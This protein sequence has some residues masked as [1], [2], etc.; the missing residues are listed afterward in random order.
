MLNSVLTD[1]HK[2]GLTLNLN[3]LGVV[4]FTSLAE[5]VRSSE[6]LVDNVSG[7]VTIRNTVSGKRLSAIAN[8]LDRDEA[9]RKAIFDA[10]LVTT[11][12]RAAQAIA[13]P[14]IACEHVHFA[15]NRKTS[16]AT[17]RDYL[18]WFIALRLINADERDNILHPFADGGSSTCVLRTTFNDQ[19]CTTL[20][21]KDG[22]QRELKEYEEIGHQALRALVNPSDTVGALRYRLLDDGLWRQALAIGGNPSL[23]P[24]LGLSTTDT[25][26]TVL[27]GDVL[28]VREWA[29]AMSGVSE[30]VARHRELAASGDP[31]AQ[32]S[33]EALEKK[34]FEVVQAS[35]MRFDEPFG[36][37]ALYWAAG[38]P[39]A[40]YG[41]IAMKPLAIERGRLSQTLAASQ[42]GS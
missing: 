31:A 4:N 38:S 36:M 14:S 29:G 26:V 41:R 34:L 20:F 17:M 37:I 8:P 33:R 39:P 40:A 18:T 15:L 3:L 25:R 21:L 9:L 6:T 28:T 35:T 30:L 19:D 10:V 5:F 23:G 42:S 1:V 13:P 22:R 16:H 11:T 2:R 32:Q 24:L 12:Y 27:I 7:A